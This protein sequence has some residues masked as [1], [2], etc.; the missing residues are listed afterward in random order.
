MKFFFF[1][2]GVQI[3]DAMPFVP[4]CLGISKTFIS[5]SLS[6]VH[7]EYRHLI[8]LAHLFRSIII[9]LIRLFLGFIQLSSLDIW[10]IQS[11]EN[12]VLWSLHRCKL[13][14]LPSCREAELALKHLGMMHRGRRQNG[15][16]LKSFHCFQFACSKRWREGRPLV[17]TFRELVEEPKICSLMLQNLKIKSTGKIVMQGLTYYSL[18]L[19]GHYCPSQQR[20]QVILIKT[21]NRKM[22]SFPKQDKIKKWHLFF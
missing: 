22:F 13:L 7:S 2:Y 4:S 21:T 18:C 3:L 1:S 10:R 14:L 12:K 19:E 16:S 17:V 20:S 5:T 15:F 9:F 11:M 8:V 6:R